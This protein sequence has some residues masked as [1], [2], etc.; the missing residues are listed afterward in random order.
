MCLSRFLGPRL[1]WRST[2]WGRWRDNMKPRKAY[3]E[4]SSTHH[5]SKKTNHGRA[6]ESRS[7]RRES[8]DPPSAVSA[9]IL[10]REGHFRVR[11]HSRR[12]SP[13]KRSLDGQ[14][15]TRQGARQLAAF[16]VSPAWW[17]NAGEEGRLAQCSASYGAAC[18][19]T[20]PFE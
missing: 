14:P 9:D 10:K 2:T 1:E 8:C 13:P 6:V 18:R 19:N 17:R 20:M 5:R 7:P 11:V 3:C 4:G 16:A 15:S 12:K